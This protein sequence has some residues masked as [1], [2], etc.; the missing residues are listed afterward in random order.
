MSPLLQT[1]LTNLAVTLVLMFLLWL[2]ATTRRD[3]S[4]VDPFWGTGFIVVA[5]LSCVLNTPAD[6]RPG[7]LA[8]LTTVWGLRL[9]LFLL[10]R[11]WGH[12]E[13]RRYE[14]MR[15]HHGARFWWV[16]LF[17]VF[18]LQGVILWFVAMPLQVAAAINTAASVGWLDAI[19]AAVWGIGFFFET[20]GDWQLA[21]FK[22][23]PR[24]AGRVMDRGLWRYTR[25]PNYF[26]D[27]CVW[28]GLYLIAVAGGAWW[29]VAS[30][31]LMSLLL[32]KVSGVTLLESTIVERRPE[33]AAYK[34]RTNAFFPGRS[35]NS[36]SSSSSA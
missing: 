10:W 34:A 28:W 30:P 13:D 5:W 25:H 11:N 29:T 31:V 17:T 14:T 35:W 9:S 36:I 18:V 4:I 16:S 24:N 8:C 15:Q 3:A 7:L 27:F 19:G 22:A 32:M 12:G 1:L 26:G 2:V 21:R 23:D 6:V 20:V 33:Y